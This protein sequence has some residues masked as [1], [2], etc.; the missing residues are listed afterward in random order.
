MRPLSHGKRCYFWNR[1]GVL[2]AVAWTVHGAHAQSFDCAEASTAAELAICA[3]KPL[4]ELD[5]T[6]ARTLHRA[7]IVAGGQRDTLLRDERRWLV[8]RDRQCAT[9]SVVSVDFPA[10][11][12]KAYSTRIKHVDK[13]RAKLAEAPSLVACHKLDGRYRPLADA[14]P[15]QSP[16][17]VLS[18]AP[19]SGVEVVEAAEILDSA[20]EIADWGHRQ[21]PPISI[22]P[23]FLSDVR[24]EMAARWEVAR[25]PGTDLYSLSSA[26]GTGLCVVSYYIQVSKG[27]ATRAPAP[28]GFEEEGGASC[29]VTR[30]F[31]RID[32]D[33]VYF[34]QVYSYHPEM[35]ASIT[36]ATWRDGE[37]IGACSLGLSY[38]PR[39]TGRTDNAWDRHC[40]GSQCATLR[41]AAFKLV[42]AVELN[43]T[44]AR[45]QIEADLSP[46]Q[47]AEYDAALKLTD[48]GTVPPDLD[49]ADDL[50]AEYP[51]RLPYV[52]EGRVL[53]A[54]VGHFTLGWRMFS[55][56][57]VH[58]ESVEQGR[59][60]AQ[61]EFVLGMER[62]R[63][64]GTEV[65]VA[66]PSDDPDGSN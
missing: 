7:L 2:L 40:V 48:S 43:P 24:R 57:S 37:F 8:D 58:F 51:L 61:G 28:E 1:A 26:Q 22:A 14:H 15:G 27:L 31:G 25:L 49:H 3:N 9:E 35:T 64:K 32:N 63:L 46:M 60:R 36:A 42:A 20:A 29:G 56:W 47:R 17:S 12:T 65:A 62:G 38:A 66:R 4:G 11:L 44:A 33:P 23:E 10:C 54:S 34:Q 30:S 55:D 45:D 50:T 13:V 41:A 18:K 53:L 39:F 5:S 6:L 52:H 59:L 16:L 21:T 19:A